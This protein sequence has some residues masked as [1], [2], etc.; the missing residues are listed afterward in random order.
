M[1]YSEHL[2]ADFYFFF[3]MNEALHLLKA[4]DSQEGGLGGWWVFKAHSYDIRDQ[5]SLLFRFTQQKHC[6]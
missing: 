5:D 2:L 1:A 6:G 4:S 3:W